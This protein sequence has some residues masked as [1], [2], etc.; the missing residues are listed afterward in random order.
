MKKEIA[1]SCRKCGSTV[2]YVYAHGRRCVACA[3]ERQALS[4]IEIRRLQARVQELE[5]ALAKWTTVQFTHE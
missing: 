2:F 3:N 1:T 5:A 4:R